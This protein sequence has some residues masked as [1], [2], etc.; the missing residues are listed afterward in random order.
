MPSDVLRQAEK[1]LVSLDAD[2]LVSL[3][4]DQFVF[5]DTSSGTRIST[6]EDL[7][8][9]FDRLFAMPDVKFSE[10]SFFSKG[11]RGAGQWTW[12]GRSR[13]SGEPFAVRGASL[14]KL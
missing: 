6:R 11:D 9:Y 3:Y 10:V 14:F 4:A 12:G 7:K 1:A 13:Q 5:E 8:A 2:T